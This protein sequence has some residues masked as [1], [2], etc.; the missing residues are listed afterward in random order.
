[1]KRRRHSIDKKLRVVKEIQETG[2]ATLVARRYELS[3]GLVS[4]W[5]REYKR[6]GEAAFNKK[7][8]SKHNNGEAQKLDQENER[9]KKILGEKD[10]EIAILKDMLKK[11]TS[12]EDKS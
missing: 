11:S 8:S 3:P 2:N 1:M 5:Y 4:R 10:L 7:S 6:Y 9:L 12:P